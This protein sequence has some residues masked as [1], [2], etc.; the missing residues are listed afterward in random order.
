MRAFALLEAQI[1]ASEPAGFLR[2]QA[3]TAQAW[4]PPS[5]CP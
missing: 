1:S 3:L 5:K 4:K 2:L